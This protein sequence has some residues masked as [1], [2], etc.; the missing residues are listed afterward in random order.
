MQYIIY[1]DHGLLYYKA[2]KLSQIEIPASSCTETCI[3]V[4]AP[5]SVW[6]K[7][8]RQLNSKSGALK[9]PIV[10]AWKEIIWSVIYHGLFSSFLYLY[11][12]SP[13]NDTQCN[14]WRIWACE[15]SVGTPCVV[16]YGECC[17]C[18]RHKLCF[19]Y[20][21]VEDRNWLEKTHPFS[22]WSIVLQLVWTLCGL[23]LSFRI[24]FQLYLWPCVLITYYYQVIHCSYKY[25]QLTYNLFLS[26]C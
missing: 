5:C 9:T 16:G 15:W 19:W 3:F 13:R 25:M 8:S 11:I 10:S 2:C 14:I 4:L 23:F 18:F 26:T 17:V 1:S 21:V 24:N 12:R 6:P 20:F 7:V 22:V